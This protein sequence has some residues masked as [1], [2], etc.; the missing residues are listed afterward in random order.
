MIEQAKTAEI[1]RVAITG[2][3][4][5][6]G[7]ALTE[8]LLKRGLEV[9]AMARKDEDLRRL[10]EL[11]AQP[12]KG[13]VQSAEDLAALVAGCGLVFH[14]AAWMGRPFDERLA[15]AVNIGGTAKV[16]Q[17]AAEAG[18]RR[19]VL[20][21]SMAVYGPVQEGT[22]GEDQPLWA[23]GDLYGD[24]KIEAE[25]IAREEA[26]RTGLE[27]VILR[28]TMIYGPASPSW[29]LMPFSAI[30]KGL[31]VVIGS[32]EALADAVYVDDVAQAFE[33]AGFAEGV[34][35]EAF[36]IGGETVSWNAFMGA[37]AKMAGVKLRRLP[38]PVARGG[39]ALGARASRLLRRRP[40]LL[41]EMVGVMTSR[42]VFSSEKAKEKLGYRPEVSL[43]E[44]MRRTE[45]WLRERGLLRRASVALVTGAASGLG[46]ATARGL[47][48]AGVTVW[49]SDLYVEALEPL[50]AEGIHALPLDVT[51]EESVAAAVARIE[52]AGAPVDLLVNVAGLARPAPLEEQPLEDVE[53][54]FE[55]NALGPLRTS[56]AVARGM[57][58]RGWGRIVNVSSTNGFLV[59][60][61]MGAYSAS[62]YALEALS[63][64]LRLELSPFGIE[65]VVVQ[66]GSIKT[67]FT[68][69]A[70][71]S[72]REAMAR[73]GEHYRPYLES[74]LKS[75]LWG[76]KTATAPEKVAH[77]IV[78]VALAR[79][80]KA[81]AYGTL[82]AVPSRV[83]ASLPDRVKDAYFTRAA[84]LKKRTKA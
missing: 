74:F 61:F 3:G 78:K 70:K 2:A 1:K 63:D 71:A 13:D 53:L 4:G 66:P 52:E 12:L 32:G 56:R 40:Q 77:V 83:M 37:Y 16:M 8:R 80:G 50:Q 6:L 18:C 22:I 23:V 31:P 45:S 29:T 7:R 75:S 24:S 81:R 25:R 54:Q 46:M 14:L 68:E 64:A 42:A 38:A 69:R 62:K 65:V 44:G 55:V 21:S 67:P 82:D 39:A 35:G 60:P 41:P 5:S 20:A 76:E 36:N 15:T 9:R 33:K 48:A 43:D 10:E 79:R 26:E 72:L 27:L 34:A 28:P 19:V 11:G 57:R 47:K 17:A 51:S 84:G 30:Q 49:A 59:T 58:E 73:S